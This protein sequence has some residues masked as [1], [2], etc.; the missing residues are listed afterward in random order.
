MNVYRPGSLR[1]VDWSPALKALTA[2]AKVVLTTHVRSDTDGIGSEIALHRWLSRTGHEVRVRNA[3]GLPRR[4]AFL[5]PDGAVQ[6]FSPE[7]EAFVEQATVVVLDVSERERL[8][9]MAPLVAR[10]PGTTICIDH[11]VNVD[12]RFA[13][14]DVIE[15]AAPATGVLVSEML[16]EAGV[17]LDGVIASALY[18]TIVADTGSFRFSNTTSDLLRLAGDLVDAGA[19]PQT[20][21]R[22][23][24]GT[25]T[26]GQLKLLSRTVEGTAFE[27]D[28]RLAWFA[29]SQA[30]LDE[31]GASEADAEGLVEYLRLV[32]GVRAAIYLVEARGGGVKVSFRSEAPIDVNGLATTW[33]G[34]GHRHASGAFLR[35]PFDQAVR[36]VVE[37][38]KA[39]LTFP[40]A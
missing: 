1:H 4:L 29:A 37:R 6:A 30:M 9:P 17:K 26:R 12:R 18:A 16:Q 22:G 33:G 14:I 15:A 21:H 23:V 8:G 5:D 19:D 24:L 28:G 25:Y 20:I 10:H 35:L 40:A 34:G 32:E 38:A 3:E 39:T 2:S 13:T 7:D 31:A 36:E 11:H 27:C